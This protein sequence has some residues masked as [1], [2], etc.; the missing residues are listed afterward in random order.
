[1]ML[2]IRRNAKNTKLEY[3]SYRMRLIILRNS[4]ESKLKS[5]NLLTTEQRD[6]QSVTSWEWSFKQLQNALMI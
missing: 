1:M 2:S 6:N 3:K 4:T 5:Y